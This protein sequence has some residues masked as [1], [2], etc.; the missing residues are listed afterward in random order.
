[1]SMSIFKTDKVGP[2]SSR[3]FPRSMHGLFARFGSKNTYGPSSSDHGPKSA[4]RAHAMK[5]GD[6]APSAGRIKTSRKPE[7][8]APQVYTDSAISRHGAPVSVPST[9]AEQ[10][11]PQRRE[12]STLVGA[13]ILSR[14]GSGSIKSSATSAES[15]HSL[16]SGHRGSGE[17]KLATSSAVTPA[18]TSPPAKAPVCD[19]CDGKHETDSCPYYKKARDNHPDAQKSAKR[20]GGISNLPGI[21]A[22]M[23][24]HLLSS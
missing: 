24:N 13:G 9:A 11:P 7:S 6:S 14:A 23:R 21:L 4:S 17:A 8:V 16:S 3:F 20:L 22:N 18:V 19:K 15:T 1:M 5:V 12:S 10:L 2:T